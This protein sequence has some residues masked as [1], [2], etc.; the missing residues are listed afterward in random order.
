M[1]K[2]TF[3]LALVFTLLASLCFVIP[4]AAITAEN[5]QLLVDIGVLEPE[6]ESRIIVKPFSRSDFAKVLS[7]MDSAGAEGVV[8]E[9]YAKEF[10]QDIAKDENA[11]AICEMIERGIMGTEDGLFNPKAGVSRNDVVYALVKILGY[12]PVA[13]KNGDNVSAYNALA[14]KLGLFRGVTIA[15]ANE[16]TYT[17]IAKVIY[18]AMG[19]PFYVGQPVITP[20]TRC[21]F[22]AWGLTE[23]TGK[24]LANSNLGL[25]IGK[26]GYG[27]V[28]IK[29]ITYKTNIVIED[30]L[31]GSEVTYYTRIIN[32]EEVVVSICVRRATEAITFN[33][34]DV[35]KVEQTASDF[36][37]TYDEE[38][39][40]KVPKSAFLLV[41]NK[42]VSATM[43]LFGAFKNGTVT[44]LDT[45]GDG[46]YDLG[47]MS[48]LVWG[49][50]EGVSGDN[51][52]LVV[53][54]SS[55]ASKLNLDKIDTV[56][57]SVGKRIV[58]PA[59]LTAGMAVGVACDSYTITAGK[60]TF[61]FAKAKAVK[62]FATDRIE[63]GYVERLSE[64]E[65]YINGMDYPLSETYQ[66][67]VASNYLAKIA[68]GDGVKLFFD[69]YGEVVYYEADTSLANMQ[70][71]YLIAAKV[72]NRGLKCELMFKIMDS[73]G[74]INVYETHEGS[75]VLDGVK[76]DIQLS[77][78]SYSIDSSTVDFSKRQVVRFAAQENIIRKVDTAIVRTGVEDKKNSLTQDH[79]FDFYASGE[80]GLY[81]TG[82]NVGR[83]FV[84]ENSCLVFVDNEFADSTNPNEKQFYIGNTSMLQAYT[85]NY[86]AGY[87][88]SDMK[89]L[90]VIVYYGK[91]GRSSSSGSSGSTRQSMGHNEANCFIIEKVTKRVGEEGEEG[92]GLTVAGVN[93]K[94]DY[95]VPTENLALYEARDT[96]WTGADRITLYE[97]NPA[98]LDT[99]LHSGDI[100]RFTTSDGNIDYIEKL[101][102]FTSNKNGYSPV[103][104]IGGV[105]YGFVH[106]EKNSESSVLYS[107]D[108]TLLQNPDVTTY[109]FK[110]KSGVTKVPVYNVNRG[111]VTMYDH[112]DIPTAAKGNTVKAFLRYYNHSWIFDYILYLYD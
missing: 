28:N 87:D 58:T 30:V 15:N 17:E 12:E 71:G 53:R 82:G 38:E 14:S 109:V 22:D 79:A 63:T 7:M 46:R 80:S 102:D 40:I 65:I 111:T 25:G 88:A 11:A 81:V 77:S 20:V 24:V 89:E 37:I 112:K 26:A 9:E 110:N 97:C 1:M 10:A 83:E 54:T 72:Y 3:A 27:Y 6:Q 34:N 4:T 19:V 45:D 32:S 21:F 106:I 78:L 5:I 92:F 8:D 105:T 75:F 108:G 16:L 56:E 62:L 94:A 44:F 51:S 61:D 13:V 95:F 91:Y 41:N 29:G 66:D 67:F 73:K 70:Y 31:V 23:Y 36:E 39:K 68:V 99:V 69:S 64:N 50:I 100:I 74:K 93:G 59:E 84:V 98:Q 76:T 86:V 60:V 103:K 49:I 2:K 96:S 104:P 35:V 90:G 55:G 85:I 47:H 48:L 18:N 43:E 52:S 42:T 101:F 33:A 107:D 57:A